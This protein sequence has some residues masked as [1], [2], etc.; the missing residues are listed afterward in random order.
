MVA[1]AVFLVVGM[2]GVSLAQSSLP[3]SWLYPVKRASENAAVAVDPSY[4]ATLMMRRASE[5]QQ[6]VG[7][8]A[9]Q[10]RVLATLTSYQAEAAAYKTKNYAAYSY[11]KANLQQAEAS[12]NPA[13]KQMIASTLRSLSDTD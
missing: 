12:A 11:C 8:G 3:G 2:G 5:V 13:E 9:S 10:Q 1:A 6:L 4:R 7:K